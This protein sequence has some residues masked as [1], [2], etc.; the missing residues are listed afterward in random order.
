[1]IHIL[2]SVTVLVLYGVQVVT[3]YRNARGRRSAWH[4][5]IARLFLPLRFANLIASFL[6]T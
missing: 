4:P 1:M 6:I 2:I 3:G 5:R